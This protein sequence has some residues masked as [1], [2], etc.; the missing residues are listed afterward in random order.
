[1]PLPKGTVRVYKKDASG[2]EQFAGEDALDHTPKD[3]R[4]TLFV[5]EAFDVVADRVQT[6]WR[7]LSPRESESGYRISIRNR[8]DEPVE[9]TV[10]EPVGG[11]WKVL[12]SSHPAKTLDAGTIEFKV[13]LRKGEE[14]DLTYRVNV[15]W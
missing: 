9:V 1:M 13:P 6:D 14:V 8:K 12:S 15:R 10:R 4:V 7:A 5:G 11:E 3:E 2:F